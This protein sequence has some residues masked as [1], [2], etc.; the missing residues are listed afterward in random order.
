MGRRRRGGG[1]GGAVRLGKERTVGTQMGRR[2]VSKFIN[3]PSLL[4]S[5][6]S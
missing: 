3:L 5:F 6:S 2:G 4:T 1:G